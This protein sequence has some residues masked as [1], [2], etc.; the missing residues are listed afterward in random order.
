MDTYSINY[1]IHGT[2]TKRI[3]LLMGYMASMGSW[4]QI[5]DHYQ[6]SYSVLVLDN[7]LLGLIAE[8]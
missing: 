6:S 3:A 5:V 2:G 4:R 8:V 1:E 7:R